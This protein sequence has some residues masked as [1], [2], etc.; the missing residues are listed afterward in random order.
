MLIRDQ[1]RGRLERAFTKAYVGSPRRPLFLFQSQ[2]AHLYKINAASSN[3][4]A[5]SDLRS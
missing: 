2:Y 4:F 1:K 3:Y 5:L